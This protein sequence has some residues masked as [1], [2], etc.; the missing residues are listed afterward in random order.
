MLPPALPSLSGRFEFTIT[1]PLLSRNATNGMPAPPPKRLNS[2]SPPGVFGGF[3]SPCSST[4]MWIVT[5]YLSTIGLISADSINLSSF[6]HHPH[7]EAWKVAKIARPLRRASRFAASRIAGPARGV[8]PPASTA[9]NSIPAAALRVIIGRARR[10]RRE[11]SCFSAISAISA[12]NSFS[13]QL[14]PTHGGA[15]GPPGLK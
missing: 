3:F 8:C 13:A 4:V 12:V 14:V 7:Q 10:G 15:H 5:K 1:A 2:S 11:D 9:P 6:L